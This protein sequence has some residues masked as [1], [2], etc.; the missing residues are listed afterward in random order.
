MHASSCAW[1]ALQVSPSSSCAS[2]DSHAL[3]PWSRS[4]AA[5]GG[6][7]SSGKLEALDTSNPPSPAVSHWQGGS[8]QSNGAK[9]GGEHEADAGRG[10]ARQGPGFGLLGSFGRY[11][12]NNMRGA[13]SGLGGAGQI[14]SQGHEGAPPQEQVVSQEEDKREGGG[15]GKSLASLGSLN[16]SRGVS[17]LPVGVLERQQGEGRQPRGVHDSVDG[18]LPRPLALSA[19]FSAASPVVPFSVPPSLKSHPLHHPSSLSQGMGTGKREAADQGGAV[20]QTNASRPRP[21]ARSPPNS[22]Q[23]TS[24]HEWAVASQK[25]WLAQSLD[26]DQQA[27]HHKDRP[28]LPGLAALKE[29]RQASGKTDREGKRAFSP[30]RG[31]R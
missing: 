29:S 19:S 10:G 5:L 14:H 17:S 21:V 23:P 11:V 24:A 31:I 30:K 28:G 7:G 20:A 27:Q 9:A 8:S 16:A 12:S 3:P 15:V 26:E 6:G 4:A 1:P 25:P 18:A 2:P 22:N 13:A